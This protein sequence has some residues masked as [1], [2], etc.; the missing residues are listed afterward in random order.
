MSP[1]RKGV[2]RNVEKVLGFF[3]LGLGLVGCWASMFSLMIDS[4]FVG[5]RR[6]AAQEKKT[7]ERQDLWIETLIH[8]LIVVARNVPQARVAL[9]QLI[10]RL[11]VEIRR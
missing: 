8:G 1:G 3:L 7:E 11:C 5:D 6:T 4:P 2:I 9:Y 10:H